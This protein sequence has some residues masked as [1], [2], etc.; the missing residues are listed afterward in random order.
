MAVGRRIESD[1]HRRCGENK[2]GGSLWPPS[3]GGGNR[4]GRALAHLRRH[5]L[6]SHLLRYSR[7]NVSPSARVHSQSC[8]FL[9]I[10]VASATRAYAES[11]IA[12][13]SASDQLGKSS[14]C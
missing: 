5:R 2:R 4:D 13:R 8:I 10:P 7:W 1:F 6:P 12:A 14:T 11:R 3:W 9:G